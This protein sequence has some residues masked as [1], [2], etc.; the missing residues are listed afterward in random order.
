MSN[1]LT[2]INVVT[3]KNG[4][5]RKRYTFEYKV[6]YVYLLSQQICSETFPLL[7]AEDGFLLKLRAAAIRNVIRCNNG[8]KGC[9]GIR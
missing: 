4:K 7:K 6:P 1:T 8:N 2:E 5:R 9:L 3:H